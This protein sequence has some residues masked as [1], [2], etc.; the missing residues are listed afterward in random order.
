MAV[1]PTKN[2]DPEAAR[3]D[4]AIQH[5][6]GQIEKQY[7]KGS[8]MRLGEV[9]GHRHP[10]HL[11]RLPLARPRARR[12]RHRARPHR[13]DLRPR[14][15]RQDD[16]R[17]ARDRERPEGGRH[18]RLHRRRARA[19]PTYA[20]K[21]GVEGRRPPRQ[22]ARHRRAGARDRRDA[23]P[24]ERHRRIV[25]D[26]V[27][28]LVP[29]AEIEGEMGDS[30]VGLQARLMSPGA[31]EAD[32]R[33]RTSPAPAL[34]FINQ[35]REKIGVMFGSPETTAG[36]RALKFY[37]LDPHRHPPDRQD[38][39]R[40]GGRS[41]AGRRPPS[42]R[43]S[44]P[45]RSATAEFDIMFNEGISYL[46]DLIDLAS[47]HGILDKSGTWL[48]FARRAARPGPRPGAPVPVGEPRDHEGSTRRSSQARPPPAPPAATPPA[49]RR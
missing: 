36:G 33:G 35:L 42:S 14:V 20:R 24:L 41:A 25:V 11:D 2:L 3:K 26:S 13:R 16:A 46:G 18:V 44:S 38:Q 47:E 31:A 37:A 28:A 7:G 43:T 32:R 27:A 29:R 45:R 22:P 6:L 5:A 4:Q 10:G 30:F 49:A 9:A 34:I 17:P 48:A 39:G 40:R 19:R 12:R 15:D 1:K 21:L 8:V 23:R